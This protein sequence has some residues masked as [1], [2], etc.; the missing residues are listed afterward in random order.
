[1][2]LY[3]TLWDFND[4]SRFFSIRDWLRRD[5]GV[6]CWA[7]ERQGR[8]AGSMPGCSTGAREVIVRSY[9]YWSGWQNAWTVRSGGAA[10]SVLMSSPSLGSWNFGQQT[11]GCMTPGRR[12]VVVRDTAC[13][14]WQGGWIDVFVEGRQVSSSSGPRAGVCGNVLASHFDIDG[15]PPPPPPMSP[16]PP[17]PRRRSPPPPSPSPPPPQTGATCGHSCM[18]YND[19]DCDDGRFMGSNQAALLRL[20]FR[21][22]HA[23]L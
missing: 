7:R 17:P 6:E 3:G 4:I 8:T 10:G 1:M 18:F 9:T 5:R 11:R 21:P 13:N 15:L 16:S 14:G 2:G 20:S 23:R 19:K 22:S 12:F